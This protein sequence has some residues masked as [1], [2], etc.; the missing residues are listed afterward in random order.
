MYL[1]TEIDFHPALPPSIQPDIALQGLIS[2]IQK[3]GARFR[4]LANNQDVRPISHQHTACLYDVVDLLN[5]CP[6]PYPRFF[7][8]SL[9]QTKL[10]LAVSPQPRAAGEPVPVNTSQMLAVKVGGTGLQ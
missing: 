7:Y 2:V 6:L 4:S 3:V 5:S 8:Q 10:K 1:D 9:Q